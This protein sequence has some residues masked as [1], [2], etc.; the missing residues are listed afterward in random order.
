MGWVLLSFLSVTLFCLS[1]R[2]LIYALG[3]QRTFSVSP[4]Y[5]R[6][7]IRIEKNYKVFAWVCLTAFLFFS[8]MSSFI[9]SFSEVIH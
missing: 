9:Q 3:E 1:A 4:H 5:S 6:L 8:M 7:A 2:G